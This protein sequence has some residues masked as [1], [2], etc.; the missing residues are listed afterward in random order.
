MPVNNLT[1]TAVF[2]NILSTINSR[3]RA[4]FAIPNH[5]NS[6]GATRRAN[7]KAA[8][9][10]AKTNGASN[11]QKKNPKNTIKTRFQPSLASERKSRGPISG[12]Y[13]PASARISQPHLRAHKWL[14]HVPVRAAANARASFV[15]SLPA[16]SRISHQ[17]HRAR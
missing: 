17:M 1:Y 8:V 9:G 7:T 4:K 3:S 5:H 13:S 10:T 12:H 2:T 16:S 14:S 11:T 15:H 6:E